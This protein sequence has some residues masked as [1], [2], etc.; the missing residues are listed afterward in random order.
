MTRA[1]INLTSVEL[2]LTDAELALTFISIAETPDSPETAERNIHNARKAH[3]SIQISDSSMS[4]A[5]P[6]RK[7]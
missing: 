2:L 6:K 5:T 4:S 1:E 3:G 7:L